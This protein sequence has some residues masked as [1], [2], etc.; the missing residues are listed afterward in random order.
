MMPILKEH[1]SSWMETWVI[2]LSI[3]MVYK[4]GKKEKRCYLDCCGQMSI[5]LG[6]TGEALQCSSPGEVSH[7]LR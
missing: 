5:A 3:V 7:Q 1:L 4:K 6:D 2:C